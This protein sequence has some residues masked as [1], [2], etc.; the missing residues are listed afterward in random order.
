MSFLGLLNLGNGSC[1]ASRG[2]LA[3]HGTWLWHL[4]DWIDRRW[5]WN[6]FEG[7]MERFVFFFFFRV[8]CFGTSDGDVVFFLRR[9]MFVELQ[10]V[11]RS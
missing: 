3:T 4:K 11:S 1:I 9:C 7:G 5:M 10:T 2:T 6:Y 8:M